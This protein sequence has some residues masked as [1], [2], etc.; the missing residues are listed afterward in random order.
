M[1]K[2][3]LAIAAALLLAAFYFLAG[4]SINDW[5]I[6]NDPPRGGTRVIALGDSLTRMPKELGLKTYPDFL[7]EMI[8]KEIENAGVPGNTTEDALRRVE[9]DVLQRDPRVV[10]VLLG[11]NDYLRRQP[12]ESI[13]DN[14]R[15]II[16]LAQDR[17]ALVV[18]VALEGPALL[19]ATG[20]DEFRALAQETGAVLVPDILD[21]ILSDPSL[22][23]DA[24]HP[25]EKGARIMAER[26]N[27]V[28]GEYLRR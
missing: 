12:I 10:L 20:Q 1:D 13:V 27:E 23:F 9:R 28:A 8:G 22:R 21:G 7:A 3:T 19:G 5:P 2:K 16:R 11:G 24:I 18:L 4:G 14:L 17:G 6:T 25:N 15:R 26:I